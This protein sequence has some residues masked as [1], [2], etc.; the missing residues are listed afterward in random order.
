MFQAAGTYLQRGRP[1]RIFYGWRLV[2][3][4]MVTSWRCSVGKISCVMTYTVI[5]TQRLSHLLLAG[6]IGDRLPGNSLGGL[7]V[8]VLAWAIV[9]RLPLGLTIWAAALPLSMMVRN[10][11]EEYGLRPD[12]DSG[13]RASAD[14][15]HIYETDDDDESFTVAE[16]VRTPTLWLITAVHG[17]S[18]AALSIT[19]HIAPHLADRGLSLQWW[20][21]W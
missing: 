3:T 1:D 4:S 17:F 7:L 10:R 6:V 18:G 12:G 13:S 9:A 19:V 5:G 15:E 16:A 2:G 21:A 8:P 14:G 20:E 11:P